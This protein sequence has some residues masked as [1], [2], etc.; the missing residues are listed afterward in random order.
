[1][2]LGKDE[3]QLLVVNGLSDD[4]TVIDVASGK[5][6]KT[7]PVGRVPYAAVVID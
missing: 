3:S 1:V 6:I 4:M 5:A 2:T 7:I